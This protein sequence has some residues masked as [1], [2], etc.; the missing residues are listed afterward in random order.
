MNH[1]RSLPFIF[2][3]AA[4]GWSEFWSLPTVAES[5]SLAVKTPLPA[6]YSVSFLAPHLSHL[7]LSHVPL[8]VVVTEGVK[9]RVSTP[10]AVRFVI[11]GLGFLEKLGLRGLCSCLSVA[12]SDY[13]MFSSRIFATHYSRSQQRRRRRQI[14]QGLQKQP[15]FSYQT[16][17]EQLRLRLPQQNSKTFI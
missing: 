3:D 1:E 2:S 13:L 9:K 8:R 5:L 14:H 16:F 12:I 6:G 17:V 7:G 11:R 10:F 15:R 4:T